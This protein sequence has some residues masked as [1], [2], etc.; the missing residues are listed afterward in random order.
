[1]ASAGFS[2]KWAEKAT[3]G[4][5]GGRSKSSLLKGAESIMYSTLSPSLVVAAG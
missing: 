5:V 2:A 3:M 4:Q 1:M